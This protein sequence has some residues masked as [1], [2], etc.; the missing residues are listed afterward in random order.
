MMRVHL[1]GAGASVNLTGRGT[2]A[3]AVVVEDDITLVDCGGNVMARLVAAGLPFEHIARLILTHEH[4]D[5]TAGFPLLAQ[6]LWLTGRRDPLPVYGPAQAL[7]LVARLLAQYDTSRWSN[8]FDLVYHPVPLRPLQEIVKTDRLRVVA[9]PARHSVP[10]VALRFEDSGGHV[11]AYSADTAPS[12]EIVVLAAGADVLI[13]EAT[14]PYPDVHTDGTEAGRIALEA[15]VRHLVLVHL[16]ATEH[17]V[18][19]LVAEAQ[20]TFGREVVA[21]QDGMVIRPELFS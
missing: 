3:L 16:P 17:E 10:T 11:V 9:T 5:H 21:G 13:H 2:T 20:A 1:L 14:G 8:F 7:D 18:R 4:P 15:G 19:R 12:E 6:Q